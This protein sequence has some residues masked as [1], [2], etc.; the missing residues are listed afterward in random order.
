MVDLEPTVIDE[1]RIG[2]YRNLFNS[3]S[4]I[5]GKEDAA[6]NFARGFHSSGRQMKDIIL[7]RVRIMCENCSN[8]D[9]FV[10]SRFVV[11]Y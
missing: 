4:L 3:Q 9:G 5:T 10:I 8:L 2:P 6:N 7:D 11:T 1:V